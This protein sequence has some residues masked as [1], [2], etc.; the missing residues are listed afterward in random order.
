MYPT[1][2]FEAAPDDGIDDHTY[3]L[4]EMASSDANIR[5]FHP[6]IVTTESDLEKCVV[7]SVRIKEHE[8]SLTQYNN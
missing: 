4:V 5:I 8:V 2:M 6:V 3:P 7:V 1:V